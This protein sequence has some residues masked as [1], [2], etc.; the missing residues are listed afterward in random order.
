MMEEINLQKRKFK[1]FDNEEDF[2][3]EIYKKLKIKES[4]KS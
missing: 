2:E 4:M 3:E 1:Y